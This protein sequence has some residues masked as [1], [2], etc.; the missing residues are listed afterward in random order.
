MMYKH[1]LETRHANSIM[2]IIPKVNG[3]LQIKG[4]STLV[5]KP[6]SNRKLGLKIKHLVF[7]KT[8]EDC[9]FNLSQCFSIY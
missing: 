4:S 8:I 5:L 3:N 2:V 9:F 1:Q 7:N 6:Y